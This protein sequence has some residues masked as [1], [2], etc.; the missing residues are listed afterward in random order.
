M[1][2]LSRGFAGNGCDRAQTRRRIV[3]ERC[4]EVATSERRNRFFRV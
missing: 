3:P 2:P 1:A 4:C